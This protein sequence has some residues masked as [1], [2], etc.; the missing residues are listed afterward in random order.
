MAG[1]GPPDL[2]V[3]PCGPL[4]AGEGASGRIQPVLH[5]PA[6]TTL[7]RPP[8]EAAT[9]RRFRRLPAQISFFESNRSTT[10]FGLPN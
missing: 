7:Q 6:H 9:H 5:L 1:V 10:N 3:A 4:G 8:H 2:L